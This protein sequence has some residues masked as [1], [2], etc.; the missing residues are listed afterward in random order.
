VPFFT[1]NGTRVDLNNIDFSSQIILDPSAGVTLP[2]KPELLPSAIP[3]VSSLPPPSSQIEASPSITSPPST[4]TSSSEQSQQP[5]QTAPPITASPPTTSSTS[6]STSGVIIDRPT[7]ARLAA[8][9]PYFARFEQIL[10]NCNNLVFDTATIT[11]EQCATSLQ[12][13]A[14]GWCG[15]EFYDQL[16]CEYASFMVQ[17]YNKIQGTLGGNLFSDLFPEGLLAPTP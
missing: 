12:E 17:Q 9:D 14:D 13:G 2:A 11:L 7:A 6:P 15:F 4:P 5:T 3:E 8:E 10:E 16:K 1:N